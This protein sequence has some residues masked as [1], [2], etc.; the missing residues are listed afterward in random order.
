MAAERDGYSLSENAVYTVEAFEDYMAH[1]GPTGLIAVKLY[2]E[3]TMTRALAVALAAFRAQG[4]TDAEG[5][6]HVAA[7]LDPRPEDPVPLLLIRRAPY[8]VDEAFELGG[9][10]RQMGFVILFLP[11]V[12]SEEPLASIERGTSTFTE[13]VE[14]AA[15]DISPTTDDRPFFFQFERGLPRTL[16]QLLGGLTAVL[17]VGTGLLIRGQRRVTGRLERLAPLYFAALGLGFMCVEVALIQ[18]TG[19]FLG[20]PTVAITTVL[21]VLLIGGG[22]GSGLAGRWFAGERP[23]IPPW[24]AAAVALLLLGWLL[25]WPAISNHLLS[26]PLVQRI[27]TVIIALTPIGL[28]M[29]MPFP[30]GLRAVGHSGDR[31]VALAW[32]VNGVTS[33]VGSAGAV[34]LAITGGFGRVLLVGALAYTG[35][36]LVAQSLSRASTSR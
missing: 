30:L 7:F 11:Q 21:A 19:L 32:A 3:L 28:L 26:A 17:L 31:H 20:H 9:Q 18:V 33:V 23:K 5:L 25:A 12:W 14:R 6:Q 2:D 13:I 35:A 4:L 8:T 24:P 22:L 34:A 10:A 15:G 29:G 16:G 36:A 27:L 1:L